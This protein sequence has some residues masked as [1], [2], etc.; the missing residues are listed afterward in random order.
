MASYISIDKSHAGILSQ[1]IAFL[2]FPLIVAVVLIHTEPGVPAG[3][4]G[5]GVYLLVRNLISEVVSAVAV[6]LF[7]FISGYLFYANGRFGIKAYGD[8]MKKRVHTLLI[9][10]LLWNLLVLFIL[11]FKQE[12]SPT[13]N[14]DVIDIARFSIAD[15]LRVFW[16][17]RS[18]VYPM[19]AQFWFLRDLM[20]VMVMSP[21]I[22]YGIR[23]GKILFPLALGLCW[24]SDFWIHL[25]GLSSTSFFFFS[26][27]SYFGINKIDFVKFFA[28]AEKSVLMLY[29][30]SC[31]LVLMLFDSPLSVYLLRLSILLGIVAAITATSHFIADKRWKVNNFLS[32]SS[33]FIYAYHQVFLAFLVKMLMAFFSP[34]TDFGLL[35]VYF[36]SAFGIILIGLAI[37]FLMRRCFPRVTSVLTGGR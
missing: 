10:Y 21:V 29:P 9:P 20:V 23:F 8:K 36:A 6:P 3:I 7:F 32:E 24:M 17:Y 28:P 31:V 33:F 26:A 5:N 2:R 13:G 37:Y 19:C 1:T 18:G 14:K 27:G 16:D 15:W 35:S 22:Y 11:Y 25:T 4:V 30:V 34:R 12:I